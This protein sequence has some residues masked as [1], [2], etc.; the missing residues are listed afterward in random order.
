MALSDKIVTIP[1]CGLSRRHAGSMFAF[2]QA[3]VDHNLHLSARA[4]M[5]ALTRIKM[6]NSAGNTKADVNQAFD[7][8]EWADNFDACFNQ[9]QRLL[10]PNDTL[11][12][13]LFVGLTSSKHRIFAGS[14]RPATCREP[15]RR[16]MMQAEQSLPVWP[17]SCPCSRARFAR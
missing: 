10:L 6:R 8:L 11:P 3:D 2:V 7:E 9:Q 15:E 14:R 16:I 4:P 17:S 1:E 5:P 13:T 12:A